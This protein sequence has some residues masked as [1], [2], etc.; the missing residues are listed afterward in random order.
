MKY[1][2]IIAK[3]LTELLKKHS[4]FI[5]TSE[6]DIV[7]HTLKS[8]LVDAPVLALPDFS[9]S[10]CIEIDAS[11]YGVRAILMQDHHPVAFDSKTLGPKL[12]GISIYEKEYMAILLAIDQ[13][14]YY[15]QLGGFIIFTDQ[16]SLSHLN[17]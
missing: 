15:L 13:W 5:W 9:K 17:E 4:L 6:R 1:F 10:F 7:F 11:E 12:R 2:G 14:R 3:P 8:A 16:K